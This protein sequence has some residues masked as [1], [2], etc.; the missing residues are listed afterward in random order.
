LEALM[1]QQS[2]FTRTPKTGSEGKKV[3]AVKKSYRGNKTLMPVIEL[4]FALYFTG[5][6]WFAIDKHIY[7]SV[8][9]ILLFQAGFLYVGVSSLLQGRLKLSE[10]APAPMK[11]AEEQTRRA[12]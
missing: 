4:S 11:V 8:P 10:S 7:S 1:G 5:A 2:G 12:A 9:F 3:A 6:L